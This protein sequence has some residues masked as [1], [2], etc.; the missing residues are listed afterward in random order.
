MGANFKMS[1]IFFGIILHFVKECDI[2]QST[3][4]EA[5]IRIMVAENGREYK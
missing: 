1:D 4:A 2:M 3:E 5:E